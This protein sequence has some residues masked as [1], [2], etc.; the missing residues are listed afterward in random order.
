[1]SVAPAPLSADQVLAYLRDR[2]GGHDVTVDSVTTIGGGFSKRTILVAA[3]VGGKQEAIVLRQVP[4]GQPDDTLAPEYA[5]LC[6]VWSPD[7]P[8]AEPLWLE[9]TDVLGGPFFANRKAAGAP[10]GTVEGAHTAVPESFCEDLSRFLARLHSTDAT[11]L[12]AA[13]VP[14]MR[15]ADE[16]RAAID[17][18]AGKAVLATGAI[19]P[20]LAAVLAWLRANIPDRTTASI[21]HGDV[22]LHNALAENGR[23]TAV[24]DW[25]R[26]HVGDPVEDLAYLRPSIEPVQPWEDF[27][28]RYVAHG[29]TRP[30]PAAEH[31]YT[32]WQDTWRHIECLRLG[33][34]FLASGT[35]PSLI[36]GFV[37]GPRFLA[38][39]L[40]SAFGRQP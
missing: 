22:G 38:S 14:P 39:A 21:I 40:E 23:L 7:L 16:I 4:P 32:V 28:D 12:P 17:D 10:Y 27:L 9:P 35:V 29:G 18:M 6:H 31:F 33:E 37:L 1:G 26:A 34:D 15:T 36:A 5:V 11:G 2:F 19:A 13:P 20:R 24:L 3:T 30:A 8:I 25:E